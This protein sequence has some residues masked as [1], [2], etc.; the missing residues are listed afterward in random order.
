MNP[1]QLHVHRVDNIPDP[2]PE[3]PAE[4]HQW[5]SD[6]RLR[7]YICGG[8]AGPMPC[9]DSDYP[10]TFPT[11][12]LAAAYMETAKVDIDRMKA[13]IA[14]LENLGVDIKIMELDLDLL[15]DTLG[16]KRDE[17]QD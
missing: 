12:R 14:G 15:L 8:M 4:D 9:E 5:Y 10:M 7:F 17:E 2:G 1:F 16:Y 11:E 6:N 3:D 13:E